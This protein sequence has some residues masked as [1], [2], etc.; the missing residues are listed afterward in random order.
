MHKKLNNLEKD[1]L[2][3]FYWLGFLMAD[4]HFSKTNRLAV[5]LA[6]KDKDHLEKFCKFLNL[7]PSTIKTKNKKYSSCTLS[8]MDV[9]TISSLKTRFSIHTNKTEQPC[10]ISS[11]SGD[12]LKA[13]KIG[14]IDGDGSIQYQTGR[15]DVKISV[16]GH[17]SWLQNFKHMFGKAYV[18]NAGYSFVTISNSV[19]VCA[20]KSFAIENNLPILN[21]KWDKIDENFK[22]KQVNA[23]EWHKKAL[24]LFNKGFS[25]LEI[26]IE[27]DK[28]YTTVYQAIKRS[29]HDTERK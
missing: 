22:S 3:K 9:V 17:I 14:F 5:T 25:I 24:E 18:N 13:F 29:K 20:L 19:E 15:K 7:P 12:F 10:D 1:S 21:R 11:I 27:L 2:E 4:A 6:I 23:R 8:V 16:K 28:K 26:S